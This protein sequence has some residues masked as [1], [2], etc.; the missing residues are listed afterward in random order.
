MGL[1]GAAHRNG[2]G[3]GEKSYLPLRKICY[4]YPTMMKSGSYN[5]TKEDPENI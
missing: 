3:G 1:F 4:T 2:E 5:L